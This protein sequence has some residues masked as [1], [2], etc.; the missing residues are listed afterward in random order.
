[1]AQQFRGFRRGE[2]VDILTYQ[3][4]AA[5]LDVDGKLGGLPFMPEMAPYCGTRARIFRRADKTCVEGHGLRKMKATVLLEEL[6][7]DGAFHDGCQR[8]C[9]FFWKE[10]WLKPADLAAASPPRPSAA[11]IMQWQQQLP[12]RQP[13][14]YICQSTE[15]YGATSVLS[16][17]NFW[18]FFKEIAQHELSFRQ[19]LMIFYRTFLMRF[20]WKKESGLLAGSAKKK[21]SAD[22][23]LQKD[24]WIDVKNAEEIKLTLDVGSKNYGLSFVP[25]MFEYIGGRYQVD[26][27]VSKIILEQTGK[28]IF[29]HRTVVLKGVNCQGVC[30]KNCPR[31]SNLYWRESWLRRVGEAGQRS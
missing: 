22:L 4:I 27:P 10:A 28:M 11:V 24:E 25:S 23:H 13:E 16:C 6:R 17:W 7:C 2:L 5:T 31:N 8:N 1:M 19:F 18:H 21:A 29:M 14:R 9:Q 3:E 20:S 12:T 30:V 15:L 26:F